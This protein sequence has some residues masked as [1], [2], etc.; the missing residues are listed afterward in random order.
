M[1]VGVGGGRSA[2]WGYL[3]GPKGNV[4]GDWV[5]RVRLFWARLLPPSLHI[6]S[7]DLLAT[8][9]TFITL[10]VDRAVARRRLL[11]LATVR[12]R[13]ER[14]Q[15]V[16]QYVPPPFVALLASSLTMVVFL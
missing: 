3:L 12:W 7:R 15:S 10:L 9:T 4:F 14:R 5:R 1:A 8:R 2:G 13:V 11:R 6:L 16:Q